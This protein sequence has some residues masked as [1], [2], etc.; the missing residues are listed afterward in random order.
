[1]VK[2]VKVVFRKAH[3]SEPVPNDADGHAPMWQKK[4]IFWELPYWQVLEVHSV[5][6]VMHLTNNLCVNLLGLIMGVYGKSKDTFEARQDLR[7]LRERDNLHPEKT[8]DGR[9]T[10]ILLATL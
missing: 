1:M 2:D 3:G 6:D 8:N 5:I 4:S 10:Y 9:I 7:C